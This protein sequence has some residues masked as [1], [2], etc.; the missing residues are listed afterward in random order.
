M[1]FEFLKLNLCLFL[2]IFISF[3]RLPTKKGSV[4]LKPYKRAFISLKSAFISI[5]C[6][7]LSKFK[8]INQL[9][10]SQ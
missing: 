7:Q 10:E 1:Y 8:Y 3:Y 2:L 5:Y 4:T 9:A 6:L